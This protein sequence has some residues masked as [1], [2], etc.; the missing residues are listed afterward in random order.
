MTLLA[1][2]TVLFCKLYINGTAKVAT[3]PGLCGGADYQRLINENT[4]KISV[5][6]CHNRH[7]LAQLH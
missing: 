3:L 7:N 5:H 4:R 1:E 2:R 6:P